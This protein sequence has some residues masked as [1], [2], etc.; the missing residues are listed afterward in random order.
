MGHEMLEVFLRKRYSKNFQFLFCIE[1]ILNQV[2]LCVC[3]TGTRYLT[4]KMTKYLL[5]FDRILIIIKGTDC[6]RIGVTDPILL[7][8]CTVYT[9]HSTSSGEGNKS[10]EKYEIKFNCYTK[11]IR[12]I[13]ANKTKRNETKTKIY[14]NAI[15]NT[16]RSKAKQTSKNPNI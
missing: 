11:I 13:N 4:R 10:L 14:E 12:K 5:Q 16:E 1:H 3:D 8:L 2:R 15:F 9:T 6:Q 7:V